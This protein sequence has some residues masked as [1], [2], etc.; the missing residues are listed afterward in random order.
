MSWFRDKPLEFSPGERWSYSN[1]G[2]VVLGFV[3]ENVSGVSYEQF[4]RDNIFRPLGMID[5]GYDST[6]ALVPHR[7]LG[8]TRGP[9]GPVPASF[10]DMSIPHAAGGLFSTVE[11]LWRWDRGLFG[12]KLLSAESLKRMTTPFKDGYALGLLV[13]SRGGHTVM[14]HGGEIEGFDSYLAYYPETSTTVAVLSNLTSSN[15]A[16]LGLA[17]GDRVR[18]SQ[19]SET[20]KTSLHRA[21]RHP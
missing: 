6:R 11:D 13:H 18:R 8:Y 12:G 5:S 1:S 2:Y 19:T 9:S 17:L 7:A 16:Q 4:V 15:A 3:L 10:I 21:V 14:D 20:T